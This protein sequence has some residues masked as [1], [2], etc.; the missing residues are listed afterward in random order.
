MMTD[1]LVQ[2]VFGWPAI[3]ASL[4]VSIL[5]LIWKRP[6]LLGLAVALIAPFSFYLSL[7]PVFCGIALGL[8]LLQIGAAYAVNKGKM[9]LALLLVLPVFI[10]RGWL[11]FMVVTQ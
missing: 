1:I 9:P 5:G 6:R 4:R 11:V 3:I 7:T 10:V 8:P 2:I